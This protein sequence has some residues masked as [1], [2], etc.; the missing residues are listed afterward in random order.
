LLLVVLAGIL[1]LRLLLLRLRLLLMML[2]THHS[3]VHIRAK[4]SKVWPGYNAHRTLQVQPDENAFK[5]DDGGHWVI[6]SSSMFT[7]GVE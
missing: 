3:S 2:K 4:D 5:S 7:N 1:L 6:V